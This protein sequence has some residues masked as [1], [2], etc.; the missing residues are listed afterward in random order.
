LQLTR[1]THSY[2]LHVVLDLKSNAKLQMTKCDCWWAI[3]YQQEHAQMYLAYKT[4]FSK[5]SLTSKMVNDAQT[6]YRN[7][8]L[9]LCIFTA[10]TGK[11][12]SISK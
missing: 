4:T 8:M 12:I 2:Y 5:E 6:T 11:I 3:S 10:T 9:I 1:N 7:A